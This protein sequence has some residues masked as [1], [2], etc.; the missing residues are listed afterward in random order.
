MTVKRKTIKRKVNHKQIAKDKLS[1]LFVEFLEEKGIEVNE[2]HVDY[3]FTRGTLVVDTGEIDVQV[4]FITP[5]AGSN[6]Y[7]KVEIVYEDEVED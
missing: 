3:G 7:E 6:R 5:K 4:K 1:A 2:N